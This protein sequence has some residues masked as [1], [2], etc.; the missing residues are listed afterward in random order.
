M[1]SK[2]GYKVQNAYGDSDI[3]FVATGYTALGLLKFSTKW[4]SGLG[5]FLLKN[6]VNTFPLMKAYVFEGIYCSK[7][8][9][10]IKRS[11]TVLDRIKNDLDP[12]NAQSIRAALCENLYYTTKKPTYARSAINAWKEY[13]NIA[14]N[15]RDIDHAKGQIEY[16]KSRID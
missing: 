4:P 12:A 13:L 5:D 7:D 6:R 10:R 3:E 1:A 9:A 15:K 14:T 2:Y 8:E 16:F 11:F